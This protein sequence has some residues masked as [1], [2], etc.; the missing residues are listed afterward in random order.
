MKT[1]FS[2]LILFGLSTNS[3][4]KNNWMTDFDEAKKFAIASNKLLLVDFWATWCAP[5]KKMDATT[6]S[7]AEV[8]TLMKSYIPVK[9]D[10]DIKKPIARKYN[11]NA[12][13]NIIIMDGNGEVIYQNKGYMTKEQVVRLLKKYEL[14]TSFLSKEITQ[15]NLKQNF[16]SAF[17]LGLKYLDFSL[18]LDKNIKSDFVRLSNTYLKEAK[19]YLENETSL[20]KIA[21]SQKLNLLK[22][23]AKLVLNKTK[24]GMKQLNQINKSELSEINRSLY[25]FLMYVCHIQ[26][27]DEKNALE[28]KKQLSNRELKKANLFKLN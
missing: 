9:V 19:K 25:N 28:F 6:W 23:Q 26:N 10:I 2:I 15:Y 21:L 22:I 13:P 14:N 17:R 18:H 5:C 20:D 16:V 7:K 27:K 11:V 1:L 4:H 24:R 12:I 3:V 8:K